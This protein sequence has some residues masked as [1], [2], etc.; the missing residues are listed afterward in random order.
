MT[1]F[2]ADKHS[3][4]GFYPVC[5]KRVLDVLLALVLGVPALLLVCLS[6]LLI[7][8]ET[9]ESAFFVQLRP[10]LCGKPFNLYKLRSMSSQTESG[11]KTLS[12]MERVTRTGR[13]IRMLSI[14]E[15]PQLLNILKGDMS[16]VG[17]R[18]LLMQYLPLYNQE[19]A[20]RHLVRPGVSGWA[21]VNGRN[22]ISWEDKFRLDTWYVDHISFLLDMKIVGLTV[23]KTIRRKDIN[24]G[25]DT[26][27]Q[28]FSGNSLEGEKGE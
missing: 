15:L 24:A 14:D 27:M 1:E 4:T 9:G 17:P 26:T 21:Q 11:G 18:P 12:D 2:T 7:R 20:R 25:T 10:G 3:L 19:Q 5:I 13:I 6:A 16:F 22:A 28:V 23:V 8:L